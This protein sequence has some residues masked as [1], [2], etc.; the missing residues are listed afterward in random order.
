MTRVLLF[1]LLSGVAHFSIAA[2]TGNQ[3]AKKKMSKLERA[4]SCEP[5]IVSVG[6][7]FIFDITYS[8][9]RMAIDMTCVLY[10]DKD[11]E[12]LKQALY[13]KY[14]N[15]NNQASRDA[16][17]KEK[18]HQDNLKLATIRDLRSGR[19]KV[20]NFED[21][22][23]LYDRVEDLSAIM[24]A[25]LL[26]PNASIYATVVVLDTEEENVF[27]VKSTTLG[28]VMYAFVVISNKTA[29]LNP[30]K[31]RINSEI[32]VLGRYIRNV[33]YRTVLGDS[34][35]APVLEGLFLDGFPEFPSQ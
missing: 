30:S 18:R 28:D 15:P 35:T 20:A 32:R 9:A 3:S 8:P 19:T 27:R 5:E 14:G 12:E 25:P 10:G 34:R 2:D 11:Q 24:M 13:D 16:F 21:A 4:W 17:E 1:L 31:M 22:L 23:L 26:R 29:I 6:K 33:K 7:E